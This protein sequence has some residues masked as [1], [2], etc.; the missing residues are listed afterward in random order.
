MGFQ[1]YTRR[2][3]LWF[4]LA[5]VAAI[6][7]DRAMRRSRSSLLVG[8]ALAV[9][10]GSPAPGS[11]AAPPEVRAVQRGLDGLVA[12]KGGPPGAIATLH[13]GG[14]LTLSLIHI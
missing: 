11:A 6:G 1:R 7:E 10:L 5:R 3:R 14:R 13:R 4:R 12:A 2:D 9:V 8:V